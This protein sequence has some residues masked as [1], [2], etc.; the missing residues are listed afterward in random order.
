MNDFIQW[1]LPL[2]LS[3]VL[4]LIYSSL[5]FLISR[6]LKRYATL[7]TFWGLSFVGINLFYLTYSWVVLNQLP[8]IGVASF[9]LVSIWGIRLFLHIHKRSR[10]HGEDARYQVMKDNIKEP[11][12][13]LKEFVIIFLSQAGIMYIISTTLYINVFFQVVRPLNPLILLGMFIWWLGY[14]LE[15][16]ADLEL[17]M[18]LNVPSN[19]GQLLTTGVW[20][21]SRHPNYFGDSLMWWGLGLIGFDPVQPWTWLVWVGPLIMTLVLYFISGV[22]LSERSMKKKP[23]FEKYA[24]RTSIWFPWFPLTK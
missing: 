4:I 12:K 7:D 15:K 13:T 24:R 9:I 10:G 14:Q 23:G 16:T 19:R 20:S 11:N 6:S 5:M 8:W 2:L 18:F 22:P 1:T 17:K 21:W 3:A